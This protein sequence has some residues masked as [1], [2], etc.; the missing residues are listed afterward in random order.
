MLYTDTDAYVQTSSM[1]GQ[2]FND[3]LLQTSVYILVIN[4]FVLIDKLV[5]GEV[6]FRQ[7]WIPENQVQMIYKPIVPLS[8]PAHWIAVLPVQA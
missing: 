6:C 3:H 8:N 7:N 1:S 2:P 4:I 5:S